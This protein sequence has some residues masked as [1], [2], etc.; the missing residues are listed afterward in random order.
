MNA[1]DA[2]HVYLDAG[3][4]VVPIIREKKRPKIR[5]K[6]FYERRM[7]HWEIDRNFHESDSIAIACGSVSGGLVCFDFDFADAWD[8]FCERMGYGKWSSI[9]YIE[10]SRNGGVHC[11]IKTREKEPIATEKLAYTTKYFTATGRPKTAIETKAEKG[12]FITWP[13]DG[14]RRICG[15]LENLPAVGIGIRED[16]TGVARS[17]NEWIPSSR[18]VVLRKQVDRVADLDEDSVESDWRM[19]PY[20]GI[21][22]NIDLEKRW[23]GEPAGL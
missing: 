11:V 21:S 1:K 14:Y 19:S 16:M 6:Q 2:A 10:R 12:Y 22:I 3:F 20:S 15:T 9:C 13:S 18:R 8:A 5:W 7:R 4:S 23:I 17:M